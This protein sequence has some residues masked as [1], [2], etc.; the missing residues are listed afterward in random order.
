MHS[1]IYKEGLLWGLGVGLGR[2]EDGG[3][4]REIGTICPFGVASRV[5]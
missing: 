3:V 1:S 4:A 2:R 5:L